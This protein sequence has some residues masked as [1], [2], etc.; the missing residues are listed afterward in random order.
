MGFAKEK[1]GFGAGSRGDNKPNLPKKNKSFW[2]PLYFRAPREL[3][4]THPNKKKVVSLRGA[5]RDIVGLPLTDLPR[6]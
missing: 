5:A 3:S 4:P 6:P 2:A 1:F